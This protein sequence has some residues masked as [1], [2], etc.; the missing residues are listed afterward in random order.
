VQLS[1]AR[2]SEREPFQD[3][4]ADAAAAAG[5]PTQAPE[6]GGCTIR[7]GRFLL[8][9]AGGLFSTG[10]A[11]WRSMHA[12]PPRDDPSHA[13]PG[14]QPRPLQGPAGLRA[15]RGVGCGSGGGGGGGGGGS[16]RFRTLLAATRSGQW[17]AQ[18]DR[19]RGLLRDAPRKR[20]FKL[21]HAPPAPLSMDLGVPARRPEGPGQQD[22]SG[23]ARLRDVARVGSKDFDTSARLPGTCVHRLRMREGGG[24][25]EGPPSV[26]A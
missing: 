16:R 11:L 3:R 14:T 6:A 10:P 25:C 8:S 19:L 4:S 21:S 22:G 20:G 15:G 1:E 9:C 5:V 7:R 18:A 26:G 13:A 17:P 2:A 23:A 24:G 12:A